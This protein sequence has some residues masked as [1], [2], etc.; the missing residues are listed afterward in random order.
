VAQLVE[1]PSKMTYQYA[2][3]GTGW[4][5]FHSDSAVDP[6][7]RLPVKQIMDARYVGFHSELGFGRVLKTY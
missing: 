1:V 4:L 6:W 5:K 2:W 7:H 3:Q